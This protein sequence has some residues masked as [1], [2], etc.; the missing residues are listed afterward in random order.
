MMNNNTNTNTNSSVTNNYTNV[1]NFDS[2]GNDLGR[3]PKTTVDNCKSSCDSDPQCVGFGYYNISGDC[4]PK[5][6]VSVRQADKNMNLYVKK[7]KYTNVGNFDSQGNDLGRIPK[8]T[9]DNCK[10]S[11]DSDPQCVGFGYYNISGDCYPK[12]NVSVRQADKNMNLYVKKKKYTNVGNFDSQGND[13][14]GIPKTTVDNCKSSCDSNPKCKGFA[15]YNPTGD[16][17]PKTN[18]SV[19]QADK[20]MNVYVKEN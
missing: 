18:V 8:T 1:G 2:Q 20:N 5:T 7:K 4:Y 19:R 14:G 16:C 3:I 11:C 12:T 10:S 6:N 9:V 17:Y 13:L 15:Y